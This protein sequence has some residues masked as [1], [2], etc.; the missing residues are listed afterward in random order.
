MGWPILVDSLNLLGMEAVPMTFAIDEHGVVRRSRLRFEDEAWLREEFLTT[1]F[2]TL[3]EGAPERADSPAGWLDP[4]K[5]PRDAEAGAW[6]G[7][8]HLLIRGGRAERLDDAVAAYQ[9]ALEQEPSHGPTHFRAGVALRMRYDSAF[10]REGDFQA[11]VEQWKQALDLDPNQYIWRRRIQQYGARLDK[12][13]PFYDWVPTAR[14]EIIERGE[15]PTPLI[16]E[17]GGAEFAAPS[18]EFAADANAATEPDPDGRIRR[19]EEGLIEVETT[20]VPPVIRPGEAARAHLVLRPNEQRKAH[21][22]NESEPL[23][24]W[25]NRPDGCE[26][27]ASLHRPPNPP[28]A[29]SAESRRVEVEIRCGEEVAA[30]TVPITAYALYY[31]CEDVDGTCLYRRQDISA[32]LRIAR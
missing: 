17:P 14:R 27:D 16:V 31:V 29:V 11:A 18:S 20:I 4:A 23:A 13:Y 9:R 6:R 15:Q 5:P 12:P 1:R 25:V 28:G 26:L 7:Y 24:V 2:D 21:W 19:D 32:R 8:A 30:E 22:N 10:R 3:A